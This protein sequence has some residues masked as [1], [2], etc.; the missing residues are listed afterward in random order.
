MRAPPVWASLLLVVV[1]AGCG[2]TATVVDHAG[3]GGRPGSGGATATGGGSGGTSA[4]S[5]GSLGGSGGAGGGGAGIPTGGSSQDAGAAGAGSGGRG[6]GG[7]QL[8]ADAGVDSGDG[9]SGAGGGGK[10]GVGG[11]SGAGGT[12]GGGGSSGGASGSGLA[13]SGGKAGNGGAAG[14]GAGGARKAF[15]VG[16][17]TAIPTP[18]DN[19]MAERLRAH[20]FEVTVVADTTVTAQMV[21]AAD[22]VLISSSAESGN[23]GVKLKNIAVPIFC[24][25]NGQYPNQGMAPAGKGTG[26][27]MVA[28]QAA[29]AILNP[30]SPLAGGL[31][32]SVTIS[33]K[34]GDLG[35]GAPPAT[36]MNVATV[37]GQP[38]H[39]AIF[40]FDKGDQMVGMTAP[41]RR[42][43]F[44]IRED[45]AANLSA[46]GIKLFDSILA[47][48]APD[49]TLP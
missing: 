15:L 25:E 34:A 46:D 38:T 9:A 44:A 7:G 4:G 31:T 24:V 26:E 48:V 14:S 47:W 33:S 45:L 35:W 2:G 42:A 19:V 10:G 18:G 20:G 11:S 21:A 22:L 6:G 13:G 23:L 32:G 27:D 17:P 49:A 3:S 39:S 30:A 36:A 37:V 41:A 8:A 16:L 12:S 43:G 1:L 29:V 5:G 40:A 28:N